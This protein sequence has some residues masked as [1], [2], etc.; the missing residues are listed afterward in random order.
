ME[1]KYK[2][3]TRHP[4]NVL[5]AVNRLKYGDYE[6]RVMG[7]IIRKRYGWEYPKNFVNEGL[8]IKMTRILQPHVSRALKGLM[9]K[10]NIYRNGKYYFI[11][12]DLTKWKNIPQ[13]VYNE[14]IPQEV[15]KYTSGGMKNIPQEVSTKKR[16]KNLPKKGGVGLKKLG[17]KEV[18]K[19]EGKKWLRQVMWQRGNFTENFI[20]KIFKIYSFMQCYDTYIAYQE[21]H[22]VRDKEAWFS[23]KLQ[24]GPEP[25]E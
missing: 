25:E 12:E 8:I 9:K 16:K 15:S 10:G 19:L 3:F 2:E 1:G 23:A 11:E 6:R 20:D 22:N 7:A 18:E 13:E 4:N 21:A 24:R 14:I 17:I 5:E